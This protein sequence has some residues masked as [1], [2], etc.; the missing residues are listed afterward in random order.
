MVIGILV[1]KTKLVFLSSTTIKALIKMHLP[2]TS[3]GEGA[4][5]LFFL[6]RN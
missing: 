1:I 3:A 5:I 2:P 6:D 4:N